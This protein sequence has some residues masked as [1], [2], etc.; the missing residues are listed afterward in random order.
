MIYERLKKERGAGYSQILLEPITVVLN[1]T[2]YDAV[3]NNLDMFRDCA[4]DVD[5]FGNGT[6]IVRSAPQYLELCDIEQSVIEMA[7]YIA[8]NKTDI[9]S[10]KMD[11]IYHNVACRAAIKGG[12]IS[13]REELIDIA[14]KLDNDPTLRYCPHG[15]PVCIVMTKY[16]LE[17]Q[18]GR[19]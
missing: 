18:F 5:N 8:E 7:S 11:W 19:V 12:N 3:I 16:E 6:V 9:R 17:K 13:T 10:E 4:F 15:R 14:N 2:D 1:K